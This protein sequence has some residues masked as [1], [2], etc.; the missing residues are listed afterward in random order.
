MVEKRVELS[1]IPPEFVVQTL[2]QFTEHSLQFVQR[3][4]DIRFLENSN[5][6]DQRYETLNLRIAE[7]F[8]TLTSQVTELDKR[9]D[10]RLQDY[11]LR[12][13]QRFDAQQ[14]ALG[15]ALTAAEKAVNTALAS[16]DRAVVKAEGAAEKRF[17]SVNEFRST[18][19][20]Q[21][22]NLL[23]RA[24][25]EARF[26]A[27]NDKLIGLSELTPRAEHAQLV[28]S[29]RRTELEL[30]SVVAISVKREDLLPL[31]ADI[32]KL[33]DAK[34][35]NQGRTLGIGMMFTGGLA[36]LALLVTL[37]RPSLTSAP[38]APVAPVAPEQLATSTAIERFKIL[39]DKFD[40]LM[41]TVAR[42][43]QSPR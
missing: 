41:S 9:F 39:N 4:I 30:R 13:Q 3:Y 43:Q 16:A 10:S 8:N 12:Y 37:F 24:E 33:R 2:Q 20:D 17:E 42:L 14:K 40:V 31:A 21:A 38:V 15:D 25:G 11:D 18:L 1:P 28:E 19:A 35:E 26:S 6:N 36:V 34:N 22:A 27:L 32:T 29:L 5:I 23:P 7:I